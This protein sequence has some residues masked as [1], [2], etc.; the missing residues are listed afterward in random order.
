VKRFFG[1]VV[2][3][4]GLAAAAYAQFAT[5]EPPRTWKTS[6]NQ[7][8][9][10]SL[11]SFD[12]TTAFFRMPNGQRTQSPALK[13]S[14]ED[15]QFLVD[16]QKTQPIKVVMPDSV[17]VSADDVNAQIVSEDPKKQSFVYRTQHFEF[18]SQGK[19]TQTLLREVG[20]DFEAT[21]ELVK[22]LPWGIQ[23]H[24][25][26][27]DYF[28]A[29]LLMTM[30]AYHD[31][32][33]PMNS[34][35]VYMP[36]KE[37]F[38]VPFASLG[39]KPVGKSFTKDNNF[40]S[41]AMVHEL[42]HQMMHFWLDFLPQWI[43]EGT[44]EYTGTLPLSAGRFRVAASKTG[45]RDYIDYLKRRSGVPMTYP[46]DEIFEISHQ[47]WNEVLTQNP[48]MSHRLYFTSFLLVY[49]FMH[50]DGDGDGQLFVR[51]FREVDN[52]ERESETYDKAMADFLQSPGVTKTAEG[53]YSWPRSLKAPQRPAFLASEQAF[54]DFQKRTLDI[55]L[56]GR[57]VEELTKQVRS[58]YGKL[59]VK[60]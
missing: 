24:P 12:G 40:E 9:T 58:A 30:S 11:L 46:I 19:L 15:Q 13:L 49:Y 57:T 47:K 23:P 6:S 29:R 36:D 17:G 53:K 59:G 54:A 7:P 31:A 5:S 37:V 8:F 44:A 1:L 2:L 52:A 39:I 51:Y 60:V 34:G 56:N 42:T 16:W 28:H 45:L 10:A 38:L 20:R 27:G 14:S 3:V 41:H 33:G 22:A 48:E 35:G 26:T 21:Y 4:C 32:G 25:P 55:L 50:L 18:E 43:V